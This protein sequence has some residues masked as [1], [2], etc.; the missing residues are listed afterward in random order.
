LHYLVIA[1]PFYEGA[2]L[3][4]NGEMLKVAIFYPI[5]V[6]YLYFH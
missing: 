4:L 6:L 2:D 3:L 1:N 5:Q